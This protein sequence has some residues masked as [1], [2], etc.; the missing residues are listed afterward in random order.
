ML[1]KLLSLEPTNLKEIRA[2]L[3]EA[4][5]GLSG[6]SP[7][8]TYIPP[9]RSRRSRVRIKEHMADDRGLD[10]GGKDMEKL[11]AAATKIMRKC[12]EEAA[13][14][15]SVKTSLG[16]GSPAARQAGHWPRHFLM[17]RIPAFRAGDVGSTPAGATVENDDE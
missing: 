3:A 17:A 16:C 13:K 1:T 10:A 4:I 7:A 15:C 11:E 2:T 6:R 12:R 8:E 14:A 5:A 9:V